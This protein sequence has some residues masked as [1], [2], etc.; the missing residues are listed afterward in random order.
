MID[1]QGNAIKEQDDPKAKNQ[2][3]H[4]ITRARQRYGFDLTAEDYDAIRCRLMLLCKQPDPGVVFLWRQSKRVSH[5]AIWHGAE[6]IPV[7]YDRHRKTIVTFLPLHALKR[8]K[9]KLDLAFA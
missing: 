7:V 1:S 6:W 2:R 4:A 8:H 5:F 3:R 9:E